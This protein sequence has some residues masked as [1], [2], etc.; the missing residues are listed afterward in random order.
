ME[1]IMK[2]IWL[3]IGGGIAFVCAT[4]YIIY[5]RFYKGDNNGNNTSNRTDKIIKKHIDALSYEFLVEEAKAMVSKI[6]SDINADSVLT[7]AVTP[8]KLALQFL[9]QSNSSEWLGNIK[10]TEDEKQNLVILSIRD[11][12]K[13]LISEILISDRI[14]DDY[15]DFVPDDKIYLKQIVLKK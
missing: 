9:S 5:R 13:I 6:E 14:L 7:M 8:N 12:D 1:E 4:S 15:Y 10:V 11:T 3:Y 2:N